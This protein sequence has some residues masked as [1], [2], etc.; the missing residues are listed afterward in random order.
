[1]SY[2]V[3]IVEDEDLIRRG[4]IYSVDWRS[5]DCTEI[6]EASDGQAAIERIREELPDIVIMDINIPLVGG[7]EVLE[8]TRK[9]FGYSAIILTGYADFEY[10]RR[11]LTVGV[12]RFLL[13][14]VDFN[15]L[16]EAVENAKESCLRHLAYDE[17]QRAEESLKGVD[18]L[19]AVN[20]SQPTSE[21]I[22]QILAHIEKHYPEKIT[23]HSLA[24]EFHYSESFLIRKFKVEMKMGFSEYLTRYRL[25]KAVTLLRETDQRIEEI[26]EACGFL[27]TKYFNTVFRKHIG[28]SP[29][30]FSKFSS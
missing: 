24:G 3:L 14:P 26:A 1:M 17:Y 6:L 10:A 21:P 8:R 25:Q 22:C 4:L 9:E 12:V 20:R 5:M 19:A 16:A 13:K 7:L 2:K 11:A 15:E 29:R 23:L 30:Q 28:C 27:S 18:L